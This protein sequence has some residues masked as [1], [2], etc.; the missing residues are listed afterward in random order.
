MNIKKLIKK[1]IVNCDRKLLAVTIFFCQQCISE[2][3]TCDRQRKGQEMHW[4]HVLDLSVSV[5]QF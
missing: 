3:D 4:W 5:L 1:N 2:P